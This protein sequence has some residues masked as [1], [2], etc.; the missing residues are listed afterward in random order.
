MPIINQVVKGGG[1]SAPAHY[2]EKTVD[3]NGKLLNSSTIIDL[4]GVTDLGNYVLCRQYSDVSSITNIDMSDITTISGEY[5]CQQAFARCGSI[6]VN[7]SSLKTITGKNA[8]ESMFESD[9][10]DSIDINEL[11]TINGDSVCATMFQFANMQSL[12]F[13]KLKSIAGSNSCA[14]MFAYSQLVSFSAPALTSINTTNATQNMF[15][16]ASSLQV[17]D[18]PV[19]SVLAQLSPS[20][21]QIFKRC[22]KLESVKFGGLK[23]S[24]FS[25]ITNQLQYMF[26]ANVGS[27]A[28]NGCT[29]HFPSNFDPSDPNH[30]FD[31][32]TLAGYPTFGG[33]ANYIHVA[34]DLPATE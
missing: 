13:T 12:T 23:A 25:S 17:V 10:I 21:N 11:E 28:P 33:N 4:T 32:S 6:S 2:I 5:A 27:S 31:A 34:F 8:C 15:G 14:S 1:G 24:T 9:T 29:V 16:N 30:T 7:L 19:L 22:Y 26:D 18:L 3:A 20:Y